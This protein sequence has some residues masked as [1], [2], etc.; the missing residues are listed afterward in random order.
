M[1]KGVAGGVRRGPGGADPPT[2]FRFRRGGFAGRAGRARRF[3]AQRRR[4]LA[5]RLGFALKVAESVLFRQAPRGRGRRFGGGDEAVPAPEIAFERD[6]PLAGLELLGEPLALRASD[7]ADLGQATGERRRRGDA[8]GER[9]GAGRQRR[10]LVGRRDQ[11]PMRG[12]RLVDRG[13]EIVAQRRAKRRLIAARDADRVDRA[14]PGAARVG[15]EKA[16]DRAR[17]RLQPLR[18]ALGFSQR[19][20]TLRLD[21]PSLGVA[22]LGRQSFALSGG[23]R[24]GS[25]G[26][27]LSARRMLRLLKARRVERA[28]LALDRRH[29]PLPGA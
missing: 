14:R 26:D 22:L 13:V 24:L 28:A 18:G 16:R 7:H 17:L 21:L 25:L 15:A 2:P 20:A 6:Q 1:R 5:R 19:P 27:G 8:A 9:I 29:I 11:R 12:R 23:E 10:I 3:D 4:R